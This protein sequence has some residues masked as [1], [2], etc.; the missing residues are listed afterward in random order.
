MPSM[1]WFIRQRAAG[2]PGGSQINLRHVPSLRVPHSLG[3][4]GQRG[5]GLPEDED[6]SFPSRGNS[7]S[8]ETLSLRK[9]TTARAERA[10]A[11]AAALFT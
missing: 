7:S 5:W 1:S 4:G 10:Q 2:C 11:G 3:A 9:C 8:Q 6:L